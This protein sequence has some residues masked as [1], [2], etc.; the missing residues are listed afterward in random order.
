MN[1]KEEKIALKRES[2]LHK[3]IVMCHETCTYKFWEKTMQVIFNCMNKDVLIVWDNDLQQHPTVKHSNVLS[4]S[5]TLFVILY[6]Q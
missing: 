4:K 3:Q 5:L 1:Y 2:Y 6:P